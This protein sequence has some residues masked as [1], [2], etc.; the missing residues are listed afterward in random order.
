[1]IPYDE[2]MEMKGE[3]LIFIDAGK[4]NEDDAFDFK[5]YQK[6]MFYPYERARFTVEQ[7]AWSEEG[8]IT[9]ANFKAVLIPSKSISQ[10][11]RVKVFKIMMDEITRATDSCAELYGHA[12]M[13]KLIKSLFLAMIGSWGTVDLVNFKVTESTHKEDA[14]GK[15]TVMRE[16]S[17][18][19]FRFGS[20]TKMISNT[21][22]LPFH[23]QCLHWEQMQLTKAF[24]LLNRIPQ[25]IYYKSIE[26]HN[27]K[28]TVE[29]LNCAPA[30]F[31]TRL[32]QLK[33]KS[34]IELHGVKV[35]AI[36]VT[37]RPEDKPYLTEIT[38]YKY[39]DGTPMFQLEHHKFKQKEKVCIT[40]PKCVRRIVSK[41][42]HDS[43]YMSGP[44]STEKKLDIR[45]T[46]I[47]DP[48]FIYKRKWEI[49]MEESGVGRGES[50]DYQQRMA[51]KAVGNG[52]C[53]GEGPGGAGKSY[54]IKL[55]TDILIEKKYKVYGVAMTHVAVNN[56]NHCFPDGANTIQHFILN[57]IPKIKR[58]IANGNKVAMIL[59]EASMI[60]PPF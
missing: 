41:E 50:D 52:G 24:M 35:D 38:K 7:E 44:V 16:L 53:Y 14:T 4:A 9:K 18:G 55:I 59:D 33:P 26:Y 58:D 23:L 60:Q 22:M 5:C 21:S 45:V 56:I 2:N 13:S 1:M 43:N 32:A 49:E 31:K 57:K 10:E 3:Y 42:A 15:I 39:T 36:Y 8:P 25:S 12:S 37:C 54:T 46:W 51:I 29:R 17:E 48:K 47:K 40:A 11:Q 30:P 27:H 28:F 34:T 6:A 20:E 19:F